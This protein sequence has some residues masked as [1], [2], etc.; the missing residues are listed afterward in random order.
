MAG[1]LGDEA[2]RKI[3][4]TADDNGF[5]QDYYITGADRKLILDF[6]FFNQLLQLHRFQAN[7]ILGCIFSEKL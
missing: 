2:A 3:E 4:S 6:P 1:E 5:R 7:K